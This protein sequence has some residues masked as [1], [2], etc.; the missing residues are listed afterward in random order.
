MQG[1]G[2]GV[3]AEESPAVERMQSGSLFLRVLSFRIWQVIS[4]WLV[5]P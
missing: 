4:Q 2:I 3:Q 5:T 1:E